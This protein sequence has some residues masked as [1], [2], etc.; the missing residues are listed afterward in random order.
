MLEQRK[1][2]HLEICLQRAV[3]H[4]QLTTGL[5]RYRLMHQACPEMA[6][7]DVDLTVNFVGKRLQAPILISPMTGGTAAG[8]TVNRHLAVAAQTLGLAM[9]VG[10]QRP[11]IEDDSLAD[12]YRVRSVAPNIVLLANL[13]A[14]QLNYG[15]TVEHCR[16][17][18]DMIEADALVLHLNALQEC[19][20]PEGNRSFQGL[21]AKIAAVC[22]ALDRPVIVKEVG[23]GLSPDTVH[24]LFEA[25]VAAVDVAGAGGTSW[26]RVEAYRA[27]GEAG[28]H[29]AAAF[30]GWGIPTAEA[31]RGARQAAGTQAVVIGSGGIR[32]GVQVAKALA[33]GADLVG[34]ALPLLRPATLGPQPVIEFLRTIIWEL[35]LACFATGSQR[36][37]MLAHALR[38]QEEG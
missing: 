7:S 23:W 14:V 9:G 13:G 33:L 19:F 16:R 10:S 6:P 8:G 35:R 17:A 31:I 25:G 3:E 2:D 38:R 11:A 20:Q 30:E 15:Y 37:E 1:T 34:L 32:D 28:L 18:V 22:H 24:R 26:G 5:E 36:V 4:Q 27:G 21:L 29:L 12:T